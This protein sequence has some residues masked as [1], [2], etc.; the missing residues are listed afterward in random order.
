[1]ILCHWKLANALHIRAVLCSGVAMNLPL[2]A[3]ST[4]SKPIVL[5]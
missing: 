4:L 3:S 2:V 1:M 5:F